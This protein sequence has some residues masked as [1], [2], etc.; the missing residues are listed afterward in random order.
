MSIKQRIAVGALSLSAAAFAGLVAHEGWVENAM[1][2]T[3]GDRPTVGFGSTFREDGTPVQMG[4]TI[5]PVQAIKRSLAHIQKDELGI[6]GCVKAPLTQT[7]YDLMVDFAYQYGVPTLCTSSMVR[8]ANAGNYRQSC[9]GYKAY[10]FIR[11]APG[12]KE[13]PGFIRGRDGVL[14][15]DCSTPGNKRCAGVWTRQLERYS[16]CMGQ[17]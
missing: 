11:A 10:R 13:G 6:K 12:E 17:L 4:D 16:T 8:S 5:Q 14:R 7:E 2:P 9:E 1:I 3:K 15:F